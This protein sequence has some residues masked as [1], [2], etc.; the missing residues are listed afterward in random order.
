M[1]RTFDINPDGV[2]IEIN[3]DD[4]VISSS[5]FVPCLNTGKAKEQLTRITKERGWEVVIKVVIENHKWG[6]RLWRVR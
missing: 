6:V 1:L 5:I 4:M 2:R 3:W